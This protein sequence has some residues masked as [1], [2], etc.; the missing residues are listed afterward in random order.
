M[1][2]MTF[3]YGSIEN[4]LND[5]IIAKYIHSALLVNLPL[6]QARTELIN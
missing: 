3:C 5:L 6:E 2:R 4:I 1:F